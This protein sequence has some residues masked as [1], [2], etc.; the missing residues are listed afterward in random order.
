M[1]QLYNFCAA[2]IYSTD[3]MLTNSTLSWHVAIVGEAADGKV[4][5]RRL[6]KYGSNGKEKE[7]IRIG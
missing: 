3:F 2:K 6:L 4:E 1:I 7:K 5:M